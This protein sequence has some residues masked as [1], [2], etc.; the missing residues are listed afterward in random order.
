MGPVQEGPGAE[1]AGPELLGRRGP[2]HRHP[3]RLQ[4]TAEVARSRPQRPQRMVVAWGGPA[5]RIAFGDI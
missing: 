1:H 4:L 5:V 2:F 3:N